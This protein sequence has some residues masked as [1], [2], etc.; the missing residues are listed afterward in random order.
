MNRLTCLIV[1]VVATLLTGCNTMLVHPPS[2]SAFMENDRDG[3]VRD[4]SISATVGGV[5]Y[6]FIPKKYVKR[7]VNEEYSY[8]EEESP[9]EVAV[10]FQRRYGYFKYGFGFDLLSPYIQVGFVSDYF[11]VMGWSNLC[12]WQF[13][14]VEH[15]YFQWAGG[16]SVI[17]Q[18]P[19]GNGVRIGLTQ[20]LSRN[21]R[22]NIAHGIYDMGFS[23]PTPTPIFYDEIG[24]GA[25][26]SFGVGTGTNV[27][28]EFRLGRDLTYYR[29]DEKEIDGNIISDFNRYTF[30]IDFQGW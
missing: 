25:Y 1:L 7:E 21:G 15:K 28:I 20:H 9:V 5:A 16:V 12:L 17:E 22:E 11:G 6:D 8:R 10:S 26:V 14:K 30:M 2:A 19:I 13:E 23:I 29:F 27:G 18:L 4:A 24:G 3:F